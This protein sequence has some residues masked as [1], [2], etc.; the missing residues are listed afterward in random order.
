MKKKNHLRYLSWITQ[1]FLSVG[2][3]QGASDLSL[4]Y[5]HTGEVRVDTLTIYR[6]FPSRYAVVKNFLLMGFKLRQ[7]EMYLRDDAGNNYKVY[8]I[9][10]AADDRT[11]LEIHVT[12]Q[13][14]AVGTIQTETF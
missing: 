7:T 1:K 8:R 11:D 6:E 5:G 14:Y 2:S 10:D 13:G 9:T 4:I 12:Y 3:A